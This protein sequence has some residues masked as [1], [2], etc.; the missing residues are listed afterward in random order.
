M[1]AFDPDAYLAKP[2]SFDPDAYLAKGSKEVP[3][4]TPTYADAIP[5]AREPD[6][7]MLDY[8]AGIPETAVTL[9][10][11][12]VRGAIA[13][14]A[15]VA[16]ELIGGVN[17]PEGRAQGARWG[18]NVEKALT[19]TPQTQ[20]AKD[21][22]GYAGEKLQNVDLNAI[23]FAQGSV[24]A[25]MAPAATRQAVGAIKNEAGYLKEA[26][27]SIPMVK[28][29]AESKAAAN[30]A[31]SY[32]NA[33]KIDAAQLARKHGILLNPDVS[34]PTASSKLR[35]FAI[36][37]ENINANMSKA[38]ESKWTNVVK[39]DFGITPDKKLNSDSLNEV[40][41]SKE[42][43]SPYN[44]VRSIGSITID[45]QTLN[46]LDDLKVTELFGDTGQAAKTNQML[47]NLKGQLQEGGNGSKLLTSIQQMRQNAQKILAA[48]NANSPIS[49]AARMEAKAQLSAAKV[50]EEMIDDSL[51]NAKARGEWVN[52]RTRMAQ[53]YDAEAAL[54][55]ATNKIDP[56]KLA[57]MAAGGKP[58]SGV[59]G[60]IAQVAANFPEI[61]GI[62]NT[63]GSG[64]A[65]R[66]TRTTLPGIVGAAIGLPFGGIGSAVGAGLGE[67]ARRGLAK[68]MLSES[69]QAKNAVPKDYRPQAQ[70]NNLRPVTPGQSNIVPFNPANALVEPENRPNWVYGQPNQY[71]EPVMERGPAQLPA[72]SAQSTLASV[73]S[74]EA[75]RTRMAKMAEAELTAN[76]PASAPTRGG[77]VYE[78]DPVSGKLVPAS[79]DIKG[80]TPETF[81]DYTK[82]LR[83]ATDK[84]SSGQNFALS[85]AEKVAW[86]K[87]RVDLA[88]VMPGFKALDEKAIANKMMDRQ[89]VQEAVNTAKSKAA[90]FEQIAAR[91]QDQQ[92]IMQ[93][94]AARERMLD[95][96]DMMEEN[97]RQLRPDT[98]RKMQGP[99]TRAAYRNNLITNSRNNLRED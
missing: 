77:T 43:S 75:R 87:T 3:S 45:P 63:Q 40:R 60:E 59:I 88:D 61:A 32:E 18:G 76:Q 38:N 54:N 99:K 42:L 35:G 68:N 73:A 37:D 21:I 64:A 93:A 81:Q 22:I 26:A 10:A 11:G 27:Q 55:H 96:A 19:Y 31:T 13:P 78:L 34:N 48:D 62:G 39:N 98:S 4:T 15:A 91:A 1:G 94:R 67:A 71:V 72:P 69:Y 86:D 95:V 8:L 56:S 6:R 36:G 28:N 24:A 17:T 23:P 84:I 5:A 66:I 2:V 82:T 49:P 25:A 57:D 51:P 41:N 65:A 30:L 89:W 14:F 53:T 90:A 52:A 44:Q 33:S 83:S 12:A 9:G 7:G 74:E 92:A 85:A 47:D 80:A 58:L 16:G 50:M 70:I 79:Q 46:K 29:A 97:L 20:T